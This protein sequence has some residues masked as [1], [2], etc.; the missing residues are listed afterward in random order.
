MR[1][2]ELQPMLTGL[3]ELRVQ[4][5]LAQT[6]ADRERIEHEFEAIVKQ[7]PAGAQASAH[8]TVAGNIIEHKQPAEEASIVR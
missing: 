5:E 8:G 2:T 3:S 7:L 1:L 6:D 4:Y